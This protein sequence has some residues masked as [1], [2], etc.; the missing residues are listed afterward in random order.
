MEPASS[1]STLN[2]AHA[3]ELGGLAALKENSSNI[4][5]R[6][7][8]DSSIAEKVYIKYIHA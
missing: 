7:Q 4:L 3:M 6:E 1:T 2:I 8:S 5:N